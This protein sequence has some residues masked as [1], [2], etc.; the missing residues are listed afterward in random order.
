MSATT[1][2]ERIRFDFSKVNM[3]DVDADSSRFFFDGCYVE[4]DDDLNELS[5][6][7]IPE[8]IDIAYND[9][10]SSRMSEFNLREL[11]YRLDG[12]RKNVVIRSMG[13]GCVP[14]SLTFRADRIPVRVEEKR[15]K[16]ASFIVR[17]VN[18]MRRKYP[19]RAQGEVM[20]Y[21]A[22]LKRVDDDGEGSFVLL[23]R[24]TSRYYVPIWRADK[25]KVEYTGYLD[26]LE[27]LVCIE[28]LRSDLGSVHGI[29]VLTNI[30]PNE[31][32][33]VALTNLAL[34]T[35]EGFYWSPVMPEDSIVTVIG[36]REDLWEF[37]YPLPT[38]AIA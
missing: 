18:S 1:L 5:V 6:L 37:I 22:S 24:M 33:I 30:A 15:E 19:I 23:D 21:N 4:Y 20:P 9:P 7:A 31:D 2:E 38:G 25:Y 26:D 36:D 34:D 11:A 32:E 27:C 12:D 10:G 16:V 17:M 14:E 8:P 13:Y 3:I 28:V 35:V 29:R